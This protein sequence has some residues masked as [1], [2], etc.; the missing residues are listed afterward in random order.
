MR[1]VTVVY[2]SIESTFAKDIAAF[3]NTDE[4]KPLADFYKRG[5]DQANGYDDNTQK[6]LRHFAA[7]GHNALLP[8]V[9]EASLVKLKDSRLHRLQNKSCKSSRRQNQTGSDR[10]CSGGSRLS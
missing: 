9:E 7:F 4:L 8:D 10:E 6:Q 3:G 5:V 2:Q 1:A